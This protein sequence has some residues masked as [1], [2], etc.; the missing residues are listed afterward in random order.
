MPDEP[1]PTS[2]WRSSRAGLTISVALCTWN[3]SRWLGE[4]LRS[5]EHQ[6]RLPDELVVQDDASTDD[7]ARLVEEFSQRA[8]FPVKLEVNPVR[9]GSTR[10]FAAALER[11]T[12]HVIALADQDDIWYPAKLARLAEEFSADPTV[13]MAF[14]NADL[15]DEQSRPLHRRLWQ[16]RRVDRILRNHAVVPAELFARRPL[17]TGCTM[18]VRRRAIDAALPFPSALADDESPMRHDRW[19]SLVAAAVGTVR[20][21]PE[22]LLAFRVHPSQETGVLIGTQ[23]T[24]ALARAALRAV[25]GP[26]GA[27][28]GTHRAR[29]AQLVEASRRAD[30]LGDFKE[31]AILRQISALHSERIDNGSN[32]RDRVGAVVTCARGGAYDLSAR[33]AGSLVAD[34]FRAIRPR[35]AVDPEPPRTPMRVR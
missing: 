24:R 3:G 26:P 31:A 32:L 15:V 7:T 6:E 25:A 11:C 20:A 5:L 30:D 17:T 34:A 1:H 4:M 33:G 22:P 13:T 16:T 19:I 10:N 14:S 2:P 21:L 28:S 18:A 8:P 9:I 23:L 29:A 12:G 27:N 35:P